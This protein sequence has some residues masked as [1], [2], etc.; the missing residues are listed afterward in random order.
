MVSKG[1]EKLEVIIRRGLIAYF[2]GIHKE[3]QA[4][5]IGNQVGDQ[6]VETI[7]HNLGGVRLTIPS[8]RTIETRAKHKRIRKEFNGANHGQLAFQFGVSKQTIYNI[9]AKQEG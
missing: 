7:I 2:M 6:I 5:A 8:L 3:P 9:I 4:E 1:A